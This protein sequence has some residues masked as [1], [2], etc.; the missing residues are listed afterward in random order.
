METL[1]LYRTRKTNSKEPK[2][3]NFEFY[4]CTHCTKGNRNIKN[5]NKT[6]KRDK[7]NSTMKN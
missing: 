2:L 7:G 4:L 3:N 6:E 5:C 1:G